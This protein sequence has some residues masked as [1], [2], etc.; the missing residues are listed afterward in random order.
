[1]KWLCA[2]FPVLGGCR[3]PHATHVCGW[4]VVDRV[5]GNS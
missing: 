3:D 5:L 2:F 4:W 1:M